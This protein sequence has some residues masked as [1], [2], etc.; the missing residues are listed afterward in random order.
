MDTLDKELSPVFLPAS[1]LSEAFAQTVCADVVPAHW[2]VYPSR[3]YLRLA[4]PGATPI[5]SGITTP[6]IEAWSSRLI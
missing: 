3:V 6:L 4:R 2:R 1:A 5:R